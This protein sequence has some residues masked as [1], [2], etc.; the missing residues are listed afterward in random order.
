[1]AERENHFTHALKIGSD[2]RM[3][4]THILYSHS[5]F[6]FFLIKKK[7]E[8]A[9]VIFTLFERGIFITLTQSEK[10]QKIRAS[11]LCP[12]FFFFS[13]S[14]LERERKKNFGVVY[15]STGFFKKNLESQR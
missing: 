13:R 15:H 10:K 1:L 9:F 3:I 8:G 12:F 11:P 6:F 14:A 7:G 2:V 5:F 4:N